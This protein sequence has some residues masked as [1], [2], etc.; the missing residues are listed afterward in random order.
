MGLKEDLFQWYWDEGLTTIQIGKLL[1]KSYVTIIHYMKKFGIARRTKVQA[2]LFGEKNPMYGRTHSPETRRRIA[3]NLAITNQKP[4]IKAKRSKANSGKNNPMYGRKQS[5]KVIEA[6]RARLTQL[7]QTEAFKKLNKESKQ[8][9]EFRK[10]LSDIAKT[11]VGKKNPFYGK[12]HSDE[13]RKIISQ[14]N[15]GRFVG[16]KGSNWQGG[17]TKLTL[18][19]RGLV[20]N[21][22]WRKKVFERD[23]YTC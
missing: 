14:S 9:P 5:A 4:E 19:V 20:E 22:H 21:L 3:E 1:D 7:H 23:N 15:K 11:R 8:T 18:A 12:T 16:E 6:S 17:K 2:A 10:K 13:T